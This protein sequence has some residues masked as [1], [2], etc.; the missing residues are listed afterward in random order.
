MIARAG[1][2]VVHNPMTNQYLGD[3]ICDVEGLLALGV[4]VGL[5]SDADVKPSIIDEMRAATLL[6]KLRRLDGSALGAKTA[7]TL[8]TSLGAK[9]LRVPAGDLAPGCVADYVVLNA[10]EI[11]PWSPAVNAVVYRGE[12]AWVQGTF[13]GGRRAYVGEPS[14][15]ARSAWEAVGKI[16]NRVSS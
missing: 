16:A 8:G 11:D 15:L 3:G 7:F 14:R 6:Q 10:A 1:A 4:T 13:V 9:A 5:G 2:R 12:D